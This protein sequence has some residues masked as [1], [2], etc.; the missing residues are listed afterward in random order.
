MDSVPGAEILTRKS[1]RSDQHTGK[2]DT[3]QDP[4]RNS[5]TESKKRALGFS[6]RLKG[7]PAVKAGSV[8]ATDMDQINTCSGMHCT[9]C[10][11][12]RASHNL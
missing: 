3:P 10:V 1:T 9:I 6:A 12:I 2:T 11:S 7:D 8:S 5:K 4:R